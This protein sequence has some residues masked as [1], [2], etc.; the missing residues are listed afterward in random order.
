VVIKH[1]EKK[2]LRDVVANVGA[3]SARSYR[4]HLQRKVQ[5]T[6]NRLRWWAKKTSGGEKGGSGGGNGK[7]RFMGE[8]R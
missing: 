4:R 2:Y 5:Q 1:A 6:F 7:R 3:Q 8:G